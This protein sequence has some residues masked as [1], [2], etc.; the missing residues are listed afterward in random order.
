MREATWR[1][2]RCGDHFCYGPDD[3]RYLGE[4][5][6]SSP[7]PGL[8]PPIPGAE[9]SNRSIPLP[10]P[11]ERSIHAVWDHHDSRAHHGGYGVG[12]PSRCLT[13]SCRWAA[14]IHLREAHGMN[15]SPSGVL[16]SSSSSGRSGS[17]AR[18]RTRRS[19]RRARGP[20]MKMLPPPGLPLAATGRD[21]L[22]WRCPGNPVLPCQRRQVWVGA[23]EKRRDR[24]RDDH[25]GRHLAR[26][27][28]VLAPRT[29]WRGV[30]PVVGP[31]DPTGLGTVMHP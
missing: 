12:E 8:H 11:V 30:V 21:G 2:H 23:L 7:V 25:G 19:A 16:T 6:L 29:H 14:R 1:W 24:G 26:I 3:L 20:G 17:A 31:E 18:T 5:V 27:T 15:A 10:P 9:R 28:C 13:S 22:L 4:G